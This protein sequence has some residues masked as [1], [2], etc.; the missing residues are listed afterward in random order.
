MNKQ[1][2]KILAK[3]PVLTEEKKQDMWWN[4]GCEE[5]MIPA[6]SVSKSFS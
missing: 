4:K 1:E 5:L 2:E 6:K 3:K